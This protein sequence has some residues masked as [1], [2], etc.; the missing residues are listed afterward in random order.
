LFLS[1]INP[2]RK[3]STFNKID[4]RKIVINS[5]KVLIDA[6]DKGG[7]SIRDFKNI[8]GAKGN[9][10]KEFNVYDREGLNCKRLKCKGIIRKKIISAR[11]TFFCHI[12]QK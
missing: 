4:C 1:K 12:C 2:F 6:I 3:G 7:S 11:S 5:R 8:L 9:F 10:Q